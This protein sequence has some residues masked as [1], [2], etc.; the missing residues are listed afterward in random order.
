MKPFIVSL[1]WQPIRVRVKGTGQAMNR[2]R[3]HSAAR[4]LSLQ[5]HGPIP[6]RLILISALRTHHIAG[7]LK[8]RCMVQYLQKRVAAVRS[9]QI[10]EV[11]A[12]YMLQHLEYCV[13]TLKSH[14]IAQVLRAVS[15]FNIQYLE[16]CMGP[17]V[18]FRGLPPAR[19]SDRKRTSKSSCS[20]PFSERLLLRLLEFCNTSLHCTAQSLKWE[21]IYVNIDLGQREG[22]CKGLRGEH[23]SYCLLCLHVQGK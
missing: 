21:N 17:G 16:G 20:R 3:R 4:L 18:S 6:E 10:A 8:T 23:Y 22:Q 14:C 9:H 11:I 15:R 13:A 7:V 1:V 19:A 2:H 5:V 12:T